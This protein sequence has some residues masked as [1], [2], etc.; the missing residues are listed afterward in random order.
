MTCV[1]NWTHVTI[2]MGLVPLD[3]RPKPDQSGLGLR[4]NPPPPLPPSFPL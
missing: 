1:Q 3:I 2:S 4:N